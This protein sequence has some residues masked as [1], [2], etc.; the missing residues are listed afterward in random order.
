MPP[1][2]FDASVHRQLGELVAGVQNLQEAFRR[3]ED[4]SDV[5]R[6][7]VH[8]RMDEMVDRVGKLE[9]SMSEVREDVGEMKPV[10]DQ[11]RKWQL[12]GLGALGVTGITFMMIGVTFS[13]ALRSLGRVLF[14]R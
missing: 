9:S 2:N 1:E 5:S 11:V 13:D 3:S 14:G 8:R 12:M 7:S 6:A 10:T 4:K